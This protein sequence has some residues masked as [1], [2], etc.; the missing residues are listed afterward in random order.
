MDILNADQMTCRFSKI[1][2]TQKA[3]AGTNQM[4]AVMQITI[5]GIP[6]ANTSNFYINLN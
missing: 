4:E 1:E 2:F 3:V 5:Y 6:V